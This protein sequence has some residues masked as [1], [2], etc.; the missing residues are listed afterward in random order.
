M[1]KV[2]SKGHVIAPRNEVCPRCNSKPTEREEPQVELSPEK[3]SEANDNTM[4][5][6]EV[7]Q[8]AEG[9]G[10]SN[11]LPVEPAAPAESEQAPQ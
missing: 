10:V 11:E 7:K 9:E 2:C 1:E 5:E 8:P 4:S 3:L 6:E